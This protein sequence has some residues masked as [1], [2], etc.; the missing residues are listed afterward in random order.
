MNDKVYSA[1]INKFIEIYQNSTPYESNIF[2][3][4]IRLLNLFEQRE[5][6]MTHEE[7]RDV[8]EALTTYQ[9]HSDSNKERLIN[10]LEM[11]SNYAKSI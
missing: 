9:I 7:V 5:T 1:Y 8:L 4:I 3:N 6:G 2:E 10:Q 11:L